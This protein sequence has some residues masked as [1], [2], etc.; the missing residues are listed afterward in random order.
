MGIEEPVE[1]EQRY[2]G[3]AVLIETALYGNG[4]HLPL[5]MSSN[6]L[7]YQH[8]AIAGQ[9]DVLGLVQFFAC[10]TFLV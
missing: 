5:L 7:K 2:R 10:L 6:Y 3:N 8:V 4:Q 9:S 1:V